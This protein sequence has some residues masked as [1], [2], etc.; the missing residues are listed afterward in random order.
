MTMNMKKRY[1][2]FVVHN[3]FVKSNPL[4]DLNNNWAVFLI[5]SFIKTEG[6]SR[7]AV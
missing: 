1:H 7:V 3:D 6:P 2:C 5:I 4:H